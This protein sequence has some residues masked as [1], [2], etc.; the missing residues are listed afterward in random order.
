MFS[1]ITPFALSNNNLLCNID[2]QSQLPHITLPYAI[3]IILST[4]SMSSVLI[5]VR[6]I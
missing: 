2:K 1:H 3:V 5:K 6:S 4:K